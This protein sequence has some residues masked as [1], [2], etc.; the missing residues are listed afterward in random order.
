M[1][2]DLPFRSTYPASQAMSVCALGVGH[3]NTLE[4]DTV[5]GERVH[6]HGK[7]L[8]LGGWR[9]STMTLLPLICDSGLKLNTLVCFCN[10]NY[11]TTIKG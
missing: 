4:F 10:G 8:A 6:V 1:S 3:I 11:G 9:L 5:D 2:P 7:A